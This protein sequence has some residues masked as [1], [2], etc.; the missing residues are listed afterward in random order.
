[1]ANQEHF[2]IDRPKATGQVSAD[3]FATYTSDE[4][5]DLKWSA[6]FPLPQI[7]QRI[8]ITMNSIG[9]A[10]VKGFFESAG[11]VGV[12]ALAENPPKWLKEQRK[13]DKST[14]QPQWIKD[15][16]GCEFGAEIELQKPS[17][18]KCGIGEEA[19]RITHAMG[20][21]LRAAD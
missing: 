18:C 20:C 16:I 11:F 8:Y 3:G 15:G 21:S 9:W 10:T 17:S 1:M 14:N 5:E 19:P 4:F 2:F 6:R 7:G 13:R 12:M